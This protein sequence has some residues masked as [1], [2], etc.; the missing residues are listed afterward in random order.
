MIELKIDREFEELI[1][2]LTEEE[3]KGLENNILE[4]G[5][6]PAFPIITWNGLIIDGHNRY[7][8]CR[9][10]GIE[11]KTIEQDFASRSAVLMW[12]MD[13]QLARRNINLITRKYL[14]GRRYKEEKKAVGGYDYVRSG[15][16][17]FPPIKTAERI[18]AQVGMSDRVGIVKNAFVLTIPTGWKETT[19]TFFK[20]VKLKSVEKHI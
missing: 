15:G 3:Y 16:S 19:Q 14:T 2:P 18:G 10:H 8:V 20:T 13:N 7:S 6:N 9:R 11:F 4:N 1:P 17:N 5:F 12:I